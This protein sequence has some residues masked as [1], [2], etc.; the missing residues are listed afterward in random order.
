MRCPSGNPNPSRTVL[1]EN[2]QQF[3]GE[4]G[5]MC[6]LKLLDRVRISILREFCSLKDRHKLQKSSGLLQ[7]SGH[8]I[9]TLALCFCGH[10][11]IL[12]FMG[13]RILVCL[14]GRT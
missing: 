2:F 11:L 14:L 5:W 6:P 10:C 13:R 12:D 7:L 1:L 9:F 3:L 4:Q 8:L